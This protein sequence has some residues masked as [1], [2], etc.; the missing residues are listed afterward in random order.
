MAQKLAS[1]KWSSSGAV[2]TRRA[3]NAQGSAADQYVEPLPVSLPFGK[4]NT[5]DYEL[6]EIMGSEDNIITNNELESATTTDVED[7][8]ESETEMKS[9]TESPRNGMSREPE[10]QA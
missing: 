8:M 5:H 7:M 2:F 4:R 1:G 6:P 9:V 3:N 10:H